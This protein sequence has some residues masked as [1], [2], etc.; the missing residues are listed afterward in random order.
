MAEPGAPPAARRGPLWFRLMR[1][2]YRI[3]NARRALVLEAVILLAF[4]RI[5][6]FVMP[7]RHLA[8]RFGTVMPPDKDKADGTR[9]L[10]AAQ[11]ALARDIGWAVTRAARYVPFRAVCLPQAIAA[12]A[13]LSRRDVGSVMHFGVAKDNEE[14]AAH[15]WLDAGQVHVTGYPV[16]SAFVEVA[17]F[18]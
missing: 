14:L 16:G 2:F 3:S 11:F 4:V 9:T 8:E 13:M 18:L 6:L 10:D 7:F 1:R 17:R 15:A 5:A 12:K